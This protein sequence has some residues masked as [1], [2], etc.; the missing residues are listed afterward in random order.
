MNG[1]TGTEGAGSAGPRREEA[2]VTI[3]RSEGL[4]TLHI[5]DRGPTVAFCH[6][7]FGQ[8]KNWTTVAKALASGDGPTYQSI[9]IDM[10]NH[11]RSAWTESFSY[12]Q[13]AD[14]LAEFLE[15]YAPLSLVGHSMG[16][17]AVMNLALR[18]PH[19]VDRLVVVDM[20]PVHYRGIRQFN[21]LV[22]AM[23]TLDIANLPD[24]RTA[25]E[26]ISDDVPN[27]A[28]RQ[29]LLQNLHRI[30]HH[31]GGKPKWVWQ[32]NLQLIAGNLDALAGWEE[33]NAEPFD[34]P[35]LWIGGDQADY[36]RPEYNDAMRR[37]FPR[38]RL[39]MLK[40]VGHWVHSEAPEIFIPAVRRFLDGGRA[41]ARP[42]TRSAG[43]LA[44]KPRAGGL[45]APVSRR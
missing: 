39:L 3:T 4:H 24:R 43:V 12:H 26:R 28:I 8:G 33:P 40:G 44:P 6:G 5:G 10:P 41:L 1:G 9:L 27:P 13:M 19:L 17:K 22:N 2:H 42:Q 36:V 11:G 16:G 32:P 18:Y 15:P 23:V 14:D 45:M 31:N 25:E 20:S 29:F 38:S 34:G 7:V 37:W 30:Q 21:H 35:V